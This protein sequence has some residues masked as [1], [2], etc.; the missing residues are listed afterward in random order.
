MSAINVERVQR[1]YAAFGRGDLPALLDGLAP[2]V[3]WAVDGPASVP[4]S[5]T[6]HGRAEVAQFFQAI[7]T[8]LAIEEFSPREF[9]ADGDRVVV[10]G[11]ERGRAIPTGIAYAGHWAH[12]FTLRNGEVV[13][14]REYSNTAALAEAF[15]GTGR[16]AA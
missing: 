6:R 13:A 9:V 1:L 7:G 12:V 3:S 10:L 2:D 11:Y 4:L 8:Y 5:G 14:F 15:H 16:C